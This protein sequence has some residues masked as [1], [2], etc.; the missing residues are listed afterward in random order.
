MRRPRKG[1]GGRGGSGRPRKRKDFG[2]GHPPTSHLSRLQHSDLLNLD[3]T[4]DTVCTDESD[5]IMDPSPDYVDPAV[6][7]DGEFQGNIQLLP[8]QND[9]YRGDIREELDCFFCV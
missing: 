8:T 9:A 4:Y 6:D 1:H 5:T 2:E 7:D 3:Q